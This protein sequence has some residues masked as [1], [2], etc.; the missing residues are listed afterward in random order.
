MPL[1]KLTRHKDFKALLE[2]F[3]SLTVLNGIN[4]FFPLV[5]I[6]YLTRVLGVE[7]YG[8]YAFTFA[9]LNYLLLLSKYGFDLSA[10]K[11][12]AIIRD[13][14]N[15]LEQLFS[16]V[17]GA[18]LF[19]VVIALVII[20]VLTLFIP[21]FQKIDTV[22][23]SG[24]GVFIGNALI[25]IWFF[26]GM[27]KM[28]FMTII[29][30]V[31]RAVSTGLIFV[32]V[33]S[34]TDLA[35]AFQFHSIGFILGGVLSL[36]LAYRYFKMRFVFPGLKSVKHQLQ[37]GWQLFVSIIG[38]NF[39]RESNV[40]ILGFLTSNTFVGYYAASEKV[41]KAIQSLL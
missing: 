30:F 40:I 8:V 1:K 4:F 7:G 5:L 28:K 37:D 24:M 35:L 13:D 11:Q 12:V 10:T 19:L 27:E 29:N 17:L 38:I 36:F 6:P 20:V 16:A 23:Y 18:R 31:V 34:P 33:K 15:K 32:F 39:Y 22:L 14:K 9:V 21:K 26:Q 41:I 25:P 3:V 2:N